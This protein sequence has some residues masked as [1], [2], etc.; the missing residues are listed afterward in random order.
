ME[1]Y[2]TLLMS[3]FG[4]EKSTAYTKER[5]KLCVNDMIVDKD[6]LCKNP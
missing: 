4:N 5:I 1:Q 6:A 3:L 2:V